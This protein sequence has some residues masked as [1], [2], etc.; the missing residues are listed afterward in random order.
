GEMQRDIL[1][2]SGVHAIYGMRLWFS[3]RESKCIAYTF[4]TGYDF[5]INL[6]QRLLDLNIS[7]TQIQHSDLL[8]I[9]G[10]NTFKSINKR[11]FEYQTP[12]IE[13]K[14]D[15]MP[16]SYLNSRIFHIICYPIEVSKYVTDILRL[17]DKQLP[18]PIFIWEP[19]PECA[20]KEY[21]Q[22]WI[23]AMKMVD[24]ISPNHEEVAA[25]LG[26]ITENYKENEKLPTSKMLIYMADKLLEHQISSNGN[27]CVIIRASRE[28]YVTGAGNAF[29]GGFMAGLLKSKF[30]IF[31]AALYGTIS[32]S[33][34]IEQIG[35]PRPK[36]NVQDIEAW[37][38]SDS[39][40]LRLH[41]LKLRIKKS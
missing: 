1:G 13:T 12:L 6:Q 24:I 15:D 38:S 32:A 29:C 31:Q 11:M 20:L 34:T 7:L 27:G 16:I 22:S 8:S 41:N 26:L 37:N 40:Q 10:L 21:M 36:I 18:L 33:F 23:E 28:G 5:P 25:L 39:P 4:H 35:V 9:R 19:V 30:D 14:P 3:S 17:R 2:G